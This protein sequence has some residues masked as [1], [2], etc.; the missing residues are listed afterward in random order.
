[1]FAYFYLKSVIYKY[2]SDNQVEKVV[3]KKKSVKPRQPRQKQAETCEEPGDYS[4]LTPL[5]R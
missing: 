2:I 1:M 5:R 3:A 4:L